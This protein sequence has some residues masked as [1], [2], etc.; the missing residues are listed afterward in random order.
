MTSHGILWRTCKAILKPVYRNL[1]CRGDVTR[2]VTRPSR[3][4]SSC[5]PMYNHKVT[6]I[7][8]IPIFVQMTALTSYFQHICISKVSPIIVHLLSIHSYGNTLKYMSYLLSIPASNL[9]KDPGC[10]YQ[11]DIDQNKYRYLTHINRSITITNLNEL[12]QH[13]QAQ[14]WPYV[15]VSP[16]WSRDHNNRTYTRILTYMK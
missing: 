5:W 10:W 16:D 15:S 3:V 7:I 8:F 1:T 6:F 13:K 4:A 12:K 14:T 9:Q 11:L 2:D